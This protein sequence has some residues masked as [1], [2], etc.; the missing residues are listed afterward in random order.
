MSIYIYL[1]VRVY[2]HATLILI[3]EFVFRIF[4][5]YSKWLSVYVNVCNYVLAV[6]KVEISIE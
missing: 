3:T 4:N 1:R 6:A 2:K 5:D